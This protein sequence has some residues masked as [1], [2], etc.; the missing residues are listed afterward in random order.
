[1]YVCMYLCMFVSMYAYTHTQTQMRGMVQKLASEGEG[2]RV[3]D[4]LQLVAAHINLAQTQ[5]SRY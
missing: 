1:M 5:Y 2:S 3:N 4:V